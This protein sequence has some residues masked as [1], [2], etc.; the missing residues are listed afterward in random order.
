MMYFFGCAGLCCCM[1][2]VSSCSERGLLSSCSAQISPVWFFFFF[3]FSFIFIS[4]GLITLQYCSGFSRCRA[5]APGM[6][7]AVVVAHGL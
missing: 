7:A 2:A 1:W 4:W 3:F 6:Q 5:W